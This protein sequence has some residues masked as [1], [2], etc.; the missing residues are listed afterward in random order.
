MHSPVHTQTNIHWYV[1]TYARGKAY[2]WQGSLLLGCSHAC[3]CWPFKKLQAFSNS[4]S[5]PVSAPAHAPASTPAPALC[6]LFTSKFSAQLIDNLRMRMFSTVPFGTHTRTHTH[7]YFYLVFLLRT[8][9]LIVP[10]APFIRTRIFV[11]SWQTACKTVS[12]S[13]SRWT[14]QNGCNYAMPAGRQVDQA[15]GRW[16]EEAENG[17]RTNSKKG[18]GQESHSRLEGH[19]HI[20]LTPNSFTFMHLNHTSYTEWYMYVHI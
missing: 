12:M 13:M 15:G 9:A 18:N 5:I 16:Q 14:A 7:K 4:D 10:S 11:K 17:T 3:K 1:H 2:G 20:H 6:A 19:T 8:R